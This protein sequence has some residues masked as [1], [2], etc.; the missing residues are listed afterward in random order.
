MTPPRA[1]SISKVEKGRNAVVEDNF[2]INTGLSSDDL[3]NSGAGIGVGYFTDSDF[4]DPDNTGFVE[5]FDAI[6]RDNTIVNTK[7]AGIMIFA[8]SNP[9]VYGST[10]YNVAIQPWTAAGGI[11]IGGQQNEGVQASGRIR[12]P[13][14]T[15]SSS[16]A[17]DPNHAEGY[18]PAVRRC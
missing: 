11:F 14:P 2:I 1:V 5:T 15:T 4:F 3:P 18:T 9:H 12:Q 17:R 6:V 16:L 10:L 8:S 13:L 7:D